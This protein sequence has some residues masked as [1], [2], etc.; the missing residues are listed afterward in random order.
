MA[1]SAPVA[2]AYGTGTV[3]NTVLD[4]TDLTGLT[5]ELVS[6]PDR[7]RL[8]VNANAIRYRYDGGDPAVDEGHYVPTNG[9]LRLDHNTNIRNLRFIRDGGSDADVSVTLEKF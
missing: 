1:L 8:T 2:F 3:S 9:E 6:Q 5:A 4:L 7:L